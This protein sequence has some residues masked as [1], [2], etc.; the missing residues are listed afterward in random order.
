[1]LFPT[2]TNPGFSTLPFTT[3]RRVYPRLAG[4]SDPPDARK[5]EGSVRER[6]SLERTV[7]VRAGLGGRY[8]DLGGIGVRGATPPE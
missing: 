5:A 7:F 2:G 4:R 3:G 8:H 1:M 6:A